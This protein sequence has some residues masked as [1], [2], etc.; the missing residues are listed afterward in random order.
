MDEV[1]ERIRAVEALVGRI[2]PSRHNLVFEALEADEQG[3]LLFAGEV[4]SSGAHSPAGVFINGLRLGEHKRRIGSQTT[5][6][7]YHR[8]PPPTAEEMARRAKL[9]AEW[10]KVKNAIR[11]YPEAAAMF[12]Q[13]QAD[14][15]DP[16]NPTNEEGIR[17]KLAILA[18]AEYEESR[19]GRPTPDVPFALRS[20]SGE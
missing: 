4:A 5:A 7:R 13:F 20:I 3:V 11:T 9:A 17:C 15:A 12:R 6:R 18:Y 8:P 2:H 16:A 10:R 14:C 19:N 1:Q